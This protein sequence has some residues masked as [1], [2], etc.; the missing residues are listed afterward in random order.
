MF[1]GLVQ[2]I[3]IVRA[4]EK[5]GMDMRA[6]IE[7]HLSLEN[8]SI[9]ASICCAGVCLSVTD[10]TEK[11]FFVDISA[12]TLSK[13]SLA[14]WGD[15]KRI[16]LEPSL[17]LGDELGGHFVFGHVDGLA[18]VEALDPSGVSLRVRLKAP[19]GLERFIAAKGS[20]ALDGVSLTVNHVQ[21]A[22]FEVNII[23]HTAAYTTLSMLS[24]GD[25]LNMEVDMLARYVAKM[26]G[27]P[28]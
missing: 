9:G 19:E 24:P 2:D 1:T 7:T 4:V 18:R 28:R 12:E 3:G 6:E 10:K 27:Q 5:N 14:Q 13:T 16:N 15:G 8:M 22:F 25:L 20:V 21:D 11:S 17:R 23:P 26:V